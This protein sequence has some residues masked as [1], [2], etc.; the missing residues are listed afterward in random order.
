M[1]NYRSEKLVSLSLVLLSATLLCG[2][3]RCQQ[4]YYF[5]PKANA[6][7]TATTTGEAEDTATPTGKAEET[8]TPTPVRTET[9]TKIPTTASTVEPAMYLKAQQAASFLQGLSNL[10]KQK[11][12]NTPGAVKQ[13][14][15][16][17]TGTL[18]G[19]WLGQIKKKKSARIDSDHDGYTNE[20][21]AA[22]GSDS[23]NPVSTPRIV[24]KT[25]L[26]Q[27]LAAEGDADGNGIIDKDDKNPA[28]S[29]QINTGCAAGLMM[30][31]EIDPRTPPKKIQDIDG[32]CLADE[33]EMG[34][35]L[36]P[37]IIDTDYDGLWDGQELLI[38]SNPLDPDT[39]SDGILDGKEVELGSDPVVPDTEVE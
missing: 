39:D 5:A 35:G 16:Q 32:D 20:L 7:P 21:E 9:P 17:K 30:L 33:F 15:Q 6:G 36:N 34:Y 18:S 10:E 31:Q 24:P 13:E 38:G 14:S 12:E 19:N 25:N 37:K 26:A 23:E 1:K 22:A 8:E 29:T 2:V 27:R 3:N 28:L 11:K 4:D